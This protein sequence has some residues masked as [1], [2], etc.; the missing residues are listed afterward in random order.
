VGLPAT[1]Y[2]DAQPGLSPGL[3]PV[4]QPVP[5]P[6]SIWAAAPLPAPGAAVVALGLGVP[7]AA[8]GGAAM[9][10]HGVAA[11]P[12]GAGGLAG[13]AAKRLPSDDPAYPFIVKISNTSKVP[14]G[15]A[16]ARG[17]GPAV[18]ARAADASRV[19]RPAP[20]A[21]RPAPPRPPPHLLAP[22][23]P[24]PHRAPA[25]RTP[26]VAGK[27]AH[28]LRAC[29]WPTLLVAGNGSIHAAVKCCITAGRFVQ[30]DG[31]VIEFEPLFR[32]PDHSRALL[33]LCVLPPTTAAPVVAA[34]PSGG[35]A[36]DAPFEIKV[37]THSR[38]AKV[39]AALS[40]RLAE[41]SR[42]AV[43][44]LALG[45]TAVANAVMA[46]AHAAHYLAAT[47]GARRIA[48]QPRAAIVVKDGDQLSG[49]ALTVRLQT[50]GAGGGAGGDAAA[51]LSLA[52]LSL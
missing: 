45:E 4:L 18:L 9:A 38:H 41:A 46:T 23:M 14:P 12:A 32:E 13:D 44:L 43:V 39:G 21:P 11:L 50:D 42:R 17:R 20:R 35:G 37:S 15:A 30:P 52:A 48:V 3:Q 51:G 1:S 2:H 10:V 29:E 36:H 22:R 40:A 25:P 49:V 31:L 19:P 24:R 6:G 26:P 16:P 7:V 28:S 8:G 47:T 34:G 33:A 5:P 27:I